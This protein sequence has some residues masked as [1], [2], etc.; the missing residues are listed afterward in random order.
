MVKTP[1]S[2]DNPITVH[3]RRVRV[4]K[5]YE[6]IIHSNRE[7]PLFTSQQQCTVYTI[8]RVKRVDDGLKLDEGGEIERHP[9]IFLL[10]NFFFLKYGRLFTVCR[11]FVHIQ[12]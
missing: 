6:T 12:M 10:L 4:P 9:F 8:F 2:I 1:W 3:E 5:K 11:L 7:V